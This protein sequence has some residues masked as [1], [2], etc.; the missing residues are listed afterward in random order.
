MHGCTPLEVCLTVCRGLPLLRCRVGA[1]PA[2]SGVLLIFMVLL[3]AAG[4]PLNCS[5]SP[6]NLLLCSSRC[7]YTLAA[8]RAGN[9]CCPRGWRIAG[10]PTLCPCV[11][12]SHCFVLASVVV[13]GNCCLLRLGGDCLVAEAGAA[14]VLFGRCFWTVNAA[15]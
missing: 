7:S 9:C 15:G 3:Q 2:L 6:H 5:G 1:A 10:W 12:C 11:L 8:N 13:L 4:P 14:V